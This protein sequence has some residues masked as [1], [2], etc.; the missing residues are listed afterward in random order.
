MSSC[1][2]HVKNV[3]VHPCCKM[4]F[5]T[6]IAFSVYCFAAHRARNLHSYITRCVFCVP[7]IASRLARSSSELTCRIFLHIG[8][9]GVRA[10][11]PRRASCL[12][13]SLCVDPS[14]RGVE[15]WTCSWTAGT[16]LEEP[17]ESVPDAVPSGLV[18]L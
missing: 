11:A 15:D 14:T 8:G 10:S 3:R 2:W 13:Y 4:Y 1:C 9:G 16:R 7:T 12:H 17:G 5:E 6:T 18:V